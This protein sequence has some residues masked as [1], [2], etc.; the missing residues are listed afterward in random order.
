MFTIYCIVD[1]VS[2]DSCSAE[3]KKKKDCVTIRQRQSFKEST[4]LQITQT[5]GA[6]VLKCTGPLP[7]TVVSVVV[8]LWASNS[9]AK[10][11]QT[12]MPCVIYCKERVCMSVRWNSVKVVYTICIQLGHLNRCTK[13]HQSCNIKAGAGGWNIAT[14]SPTCTLNYILHAV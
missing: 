6:A 11:E 9:K 1:S 5:Q 10:E 3:E 12:Y 14:R 4:A 8:W 2:K 13:A 7:N